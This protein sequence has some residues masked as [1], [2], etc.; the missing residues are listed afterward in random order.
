MSSPIKD[1]LQ[2]LSRNAEVVEEGIKGVISTESGTPGAAIVALRQASALRAAGDDGYRLH[3]KLR[4]YLQDHLQLFPAYQSLAEIGSRVT[5]IHSLWGEIELLCL[6]DEQETVN[7]LLNQLQTTVF[8]VV[9][10][11]DR[12]LLLLQTLISTRY[13]NVKT[14]EAKKSQ[15]RY[16]QQ[17]TTALSSDLSRL[18]KVCDN[19]EREAS[20]RSMETLARF[21]R[22]TILSRILSWQQGMTEMASM[23]RKEIFLTR[24]IERELKLL[25]RMDM[26]L[27]QQPAWRGM[28]VDLRG[29]I[30]VFLLA[31]SLPAIVAHAEPMDSDH[32]MRLE[33]E[34]LAK[35]LPPRMAR[36]PD[37]EPPVRY[38]RI[39]DP[40]RQ[41]EPSPAALALERLAKAVKAAPDGVSL[42][43]WRARDAN[44]RS[45]SANIWVTFA[46]MAMRGRKLHVELVPNMPR[47]GEHFAHTFGDA[48][49]YSVPPVRSR[50]T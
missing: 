29:D 7:S 15:N 45:M 3:P 8:D 5:Q 22:R 49:V 36:G 46:V 20:A 48:K 24:E 26:L 32:V 50:I 25:A 42:I 43:E 1:V 16:Y 17:Q 12:N 41:A 21:L 9:D 19:I 6:S 40:P 44:A 31:A 2:T 23:I 35:S 33:M 18:S 27:R 14:L 28:E 11:M 30:P 10:S 13:G 37:P 34:S 47:P 39:V 38:K 4:E